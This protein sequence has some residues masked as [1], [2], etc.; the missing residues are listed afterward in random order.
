MARNLES[1]LCCMN[2]LFAE[3]SLILEQ[4]IQ[5]LE[6][7]SNESYSQKRQNMD[8][9]IGEHVRHILEHYELFWE[10]IKLGHIDYDNRK[11]NPELES[12]R[13]FAVQ[14]MIAYVSKFQ[15]QTLTLEPLTISQNYHPNQPI[16]IVISNMTRELMFLISHTVHHYAIISILVKLDGGFVPKGFGFSPA[17]L[18]A[19]V[20]ERP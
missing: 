6:S 8:A 11:R 15:N 13:L 20:I 10:G 7:I 2:P 12:N 14:S 9:S 16:P 4:G 3:N 19:K 17:T 18:F 1:K 5:L